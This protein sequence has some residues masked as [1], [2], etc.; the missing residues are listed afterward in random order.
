MTM[1]QRMDQPEKRNKRLTGANLKDARI[2]SELSA[3]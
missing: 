2:L 1:D 3:G